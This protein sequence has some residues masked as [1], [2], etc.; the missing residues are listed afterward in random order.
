MPELKSKQ[1][2][3][4]A[5][6][7]AY[8]GSQRQIQFFVN[9]K[10]ELLNLAI[11]D[12][13]G[14]T[15]P[16]RWVSPLKNEKFKEYRDSQFLEALGL[17]R[18]KGNLS[19]FW[20]ARGPRWDALACV[21][22]GTDGVLLLEAKSYVSEI[23]G[24]GC[25]ATADTSI[26]RIENSIAKTKSWLQVDSSANWTGPLYQS[27]NRIAHLYFVREVLGVEAWLVNV[28]FIDDPHSPTSRADWDVGITSLKADLGIGDIPFCANVFLSAAR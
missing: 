14:K 3:C 28:Y 18:F 22:D 6:G 26:Q 1:V 7:R 11:S 15:F 20:P 21:E 4:D 9:E 5:L 24:P 13:F 16:L 27:A 17:R 12:A 19:G 2:R 23:L 8:A 10:P 25:I